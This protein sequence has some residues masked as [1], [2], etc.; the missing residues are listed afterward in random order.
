MRASIIFF[1]LLLFPLNVYGLMY[2]SVSVDSSIDGYSPYSNTPVIVDGAFQ[3]F[4]VVWGNTGS[5]SCRVKSRM[6]IFGKVKNKTALLYTAWSR[7]EPSE[8]GT[9]HTLYSYWYPPGPGNYSAYSRIYY[10]NLIFDGPEVNFSVTRGRVSNETVLK[11]MELLEVSYTTNRST[12]EFNIVPKADISELLITPSTYPAAWVFESQLVKNL[13]E[14]ESRVVKIHYQP[15]VWK[16]RNIS[17]TLVSGD[18]SFLLEENVP[19][20][21][22]NPGLTLEQ[23]LIILLLLI[24]LIL[25]VLLYR[26]RK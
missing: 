22:E 4:T 1:T 25:L 17:F 5:V 23:M 10:C 15:T 3:T 8:P 11:S 12:V 21:K 19:L 6:D 20:R 9:M 26:A 14:G 16:R 24:V 13:V 7:E 18:G 2:V